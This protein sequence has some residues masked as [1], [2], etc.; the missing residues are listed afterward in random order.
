MRRQ[1][2]NSSARGPLEV[3]RG[4]RGLQVA[5]GLRQRASAIA[6]EEEPTWQR[7]RVEGRRGD[8]SQRVERGS[9][10]RCQKEEERRGQR[11]RGRK[12]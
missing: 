5:R 4:P 8:L 6:Q 12:G 7:R 11:N 10:R 1:G 3:A 2:K 9:S